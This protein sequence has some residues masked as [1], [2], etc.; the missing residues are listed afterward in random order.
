MVGPCVT[1]N[2]TQLLNSFYMKSTTPK[3]RPASTRKNRPA[4]AA[5]LFLGQKLVRELRI[6]MRLASGNGSS[7]KPGEGHSY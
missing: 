3:A 2:P 7:I 6:L 5:Q 1:F 4:R